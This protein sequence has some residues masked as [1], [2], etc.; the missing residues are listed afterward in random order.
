MKPR[1]DLAKW[2]TEKS[3]LSV[4]EKKSD[5]HDYLGYGKKVFDKILPVENYAK[6]TY[7]DFIVDLTSALRDPKRGVGQIVVVVMPTRKGKS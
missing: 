1:K 5:T 2:G 7:V 4:A 3:Y 6:D